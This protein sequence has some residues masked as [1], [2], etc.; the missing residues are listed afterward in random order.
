MSARLRVNR[1]ALAENFRMYRAASGGRCGAVVKA[2]GYGLGLAETASVFARLG[3]EHFFVANALEGVALRAALTELG[4]FRGAT[5]DARRGESAQQNALPEPRVYILEGVRPD[6]AHLLAEAGLLPVINHEEQLAAW[7]PQRHL[8]IAVHVDTGMNRLGFTPD[9]AADTFAGFHVNLLMT[10]LACAD[11]PEHPLNEMQLRR[12]ETAAQ[13]FPG[14]ATSIGNSAGT[15]L[16]RRYQGGLVRPGIGLYGGNPWS[17][18]ANPVRPVATLEAPV[19]Q[20]RTLRPGDTVG[21]GGTWRSEDLRRLAVLGIGYADGLPRR[22]SNRGQA[23]VRGKRCPIVGRVSMD[24]TI[25]DVTDCDVQPGDW[26]ELFGP[27]LPINEVARAADTIAYEL[28]TGIA[29][30]VA[31]IHEA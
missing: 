1:S 26:A 16:G 17:S 23:V 27:Q 31:R 25:L 2:N 15:L 18:R 3:C 22:L 20:V 29:A 11:E 19:L 9:V 24:L 14:I 7:A 13:N 6:T 4:V 10:H 12:F 30:R 5:H 8:E 21:Y 28:L